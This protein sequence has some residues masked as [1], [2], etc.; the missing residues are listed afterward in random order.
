M[1]TQ[2]TLDLPPYSPHVRHFG[3]DTSLCF[4]NHGSFGST[5]HSVIE[6]QHRIRRQMEAEPIRF[7]VE[8][9]EPLLDASRLRMAAFVGCPANDFAF[10]PNA[11]TGVNTVVNSLRFASGDEIL[12]SSHEY[13]ACNNAIAAAAERWGAKVVSVTVPFPVKSPDEVLHAIKQGITPRTKL[14]LIS[15]IT[16]PT[17]MIFPVKAIIDHAR[18]LGID[19]LVDGAHAPGF[20]PLN[21]ASLGCTYYTG[22][23]HKWVC[24]PKGSAFLY[25]H[26]DRQPTIRPVVVSHGANSTRTDRS[27]FR[28]EFDYIGSLD[29]SP[30]I[31]TPAA[32]DAVAAMVAPGQASH[33]AWDKIMQ[34]NRGL[35]LSARDH[36]CKSLGVNPAAPDSMLG[37]MATIPIHPR[38]PAEN[39]IRTNY[40]DPLQDRLIAEHRIQIPILPFPAPP[41]RYVRV[42]AHLYNTFEQFEY[43]GRA[44]QKIRC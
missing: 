20:L 21:V 18:S 32:L 37:A 35:A 43:L 9:L 13:N 14:L 26:P 2:S 42:S 28:L 44:L 22:N 3:V 36:L 30:W 34:L 1:P 12:T 15:H 33:S 39:A 17:A 6:A 25:V 11:T 10:V 31:C 7:F 19:T 16:S 4:L 8:D 24:A 40:H 23:F 41:T 29:Y 5:P 38:T 27:R